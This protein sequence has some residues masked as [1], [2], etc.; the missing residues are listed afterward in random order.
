VP[1]RL[2]AHPDSALPRDAAQQVGQVLQPVRD[3][4]DDIALA[5]HAAARR[6]WR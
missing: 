3:D 4:M 5:L 1:N 6:C 2:L